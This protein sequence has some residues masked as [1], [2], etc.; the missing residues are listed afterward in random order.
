MEKRQSS[1][2]LTMAG[3]SSTEPASGKNLGT[4]LQVQVLSARMRSYVT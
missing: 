2:R 3:N 1:M 4:I